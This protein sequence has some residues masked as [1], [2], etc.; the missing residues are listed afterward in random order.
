MAV[1]VPLEVIVRVVVEGTETIVYSPFI[2]DAVKPPVATKS[3]KN[4]FAL[5]NRPCAEEVVIVK[6][7][8]DAVVVTVAE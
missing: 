1:A 6:V 3:S 8:L 4:I 5:A 2:S 7:E